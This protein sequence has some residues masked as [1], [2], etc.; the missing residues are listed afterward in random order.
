M[1]IT[2]NTYPVKDQ[3]KALG[4]RWDSK[5]KGW[6]VPADKAAEAQA[7]VAGA[8]SVP[9]STTPKTEFKHS[10]CKECGSKADRYNKIYR[11]GICRNCYRD[12]QEEADMGY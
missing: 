5:A 10:K 6:N 7:L 3:I 1:L 12:E 11:N 9:V 2:G 8:V 4:G